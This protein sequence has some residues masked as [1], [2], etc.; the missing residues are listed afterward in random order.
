[1]TDEPLD[2]IG[3]EIRRQGERAIAM[4][5]TP[6]EHGSIVQFVAGYNPA[7]LAAAL[8]NVQRRR[9]DQLNR[10]MIAGARELDGRTCAM[11]GDHE[12]DHEMCRDTVI[13]AGRR[14]LAATILEG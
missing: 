1:M 9:D 12:H 8:D 5:L 14:A 2:P 3:D 7:A 4:K 10:L 13:E 6:G 11:P